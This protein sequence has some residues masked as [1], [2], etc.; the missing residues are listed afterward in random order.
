MGERCRWSE[1]YV[2]GSSGMG[3]W[4][5]GLVLGFNNSVG[6]GGVCDLCLGCDGMGG[7]EGIVL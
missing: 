3:E 7:V 6:T 5:R 4:L 2:F 1:W